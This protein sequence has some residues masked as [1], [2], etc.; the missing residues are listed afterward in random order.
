MFSFHSS[1]TSIIAMALGDAR[2]AQGGFFQY[3]LS[4]LWSKISLWTMVTDP[5]GPTVTF[6]TTVKR[7]TPP[8]RTFTPLSMLALAI[9]APR[10]SIFFGEF[11]FSSTYGLSGTFCRF[12]VTSSCVAS[13]VI[14]FSIQPLA[15]GDRSEIG[16]GLD[17]GAGSAISST[18]DG[19]MSPLIGNGFFSFLFDDR[20]GVRL[21]SYPRSRLRAASDFKRSNGGS[22]F[23]RIFC[24]LAVTGPTRAPAV[25][26]PNGGSR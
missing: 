24:S 21:V 2:P 1:E 3:A 26:S 18:T 14:G 25:A 9:L 16:T 15:F 6:F 5:S 4:L 20:I 11:K 22:T 19:I 7:P 23:S 12:S 10:A 17:P 13:I 8:R